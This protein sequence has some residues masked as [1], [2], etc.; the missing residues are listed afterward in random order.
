MKIKSIRLGE[1]LN[2]LRF[3][4]KHSPSKEANNQFLENKLKNKNRYQC[5]CC[6]GVGVIKSAYLI[7]FMPRKFGN[8]P[9]S[10]EICYYCKGT[11]RI[12]Y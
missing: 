6:N 10:Y 2:K 7:N 8:S 9:Y 4:S 1:L 3:A 12:I 11:G 5:K